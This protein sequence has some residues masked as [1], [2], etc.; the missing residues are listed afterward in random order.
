MI[1]A[2]RRFLDEVLWR[3]FCDLNVDLQAYLME[4]TLKVIR[5]EV[6]AD[7]SDAQDMPEALPAA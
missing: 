4:A 6:Y 2:P 5:E 7:A 1:R 3:E